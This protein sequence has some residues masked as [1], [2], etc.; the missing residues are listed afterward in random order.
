[1]ALWASQ[2][3]YLHTYLYEYSGWVQSFAL[4]LLN[5]S[6]FTDTP[7]PSHCRLSPCPSRVLWCH[8]CA[9]SWHAQSASVGW[10]GLLRRLDR[11]HVQWHCIMG[12]VVPR[13][14]EGVIWF[15]KN[16]WAHA[17]SSDTKCCTQSQVIDCYHSEWFWTSV[18][19]CILLSSALPQYI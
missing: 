9:R 4:L 2:S 3:F 10:M 6:V 14:R 5:W 11:A 12:H 15:T 13:S 19:T 7:P 17:L 8:L 18:S 16:G 1:M